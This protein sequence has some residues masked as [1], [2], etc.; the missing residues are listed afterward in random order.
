[1]DIF[2]EMIQAMVVDHDPAEFRRIVEGIDLLRPD[3][4]FTD[5]EIVDYFGHFYDFVMADGDYTITPEPT[6]RRPC[7]ASSTRRGPTARS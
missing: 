7:A 2:G 4:G 6:P 5:A 3:M 1:M